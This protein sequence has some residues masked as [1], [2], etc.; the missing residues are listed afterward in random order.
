VGDATLA[1]DA[2]DTAAAP[3]F[4]I[5]IPQYN[6]TDFLLEAIRS[7]A[8]QDF[9]DFEVCIS[10]G[11]STD[12]GT[13]RIEAA[14]KTHGL[15]YVLSRSDRNL[16]YD[17]N[18]RTSIAS[19]KGR[20]LLLMGNDDALADECTLSQIR[21]V[22]DAN[23][24][25]AVAITNYLELSTSTH[26]RRMRS[27]EVLGSGPAVAASTYRH[28]S[29]VSGV[30]L[31]GKG[32]REAPTDACDGG[33]MYQMY[34]GSRLIA[35]GGRFLSIDSTCVH[36]DIQISGRAVDSY[37][38]RP[39]LHPCPL[40]ER[41]LPMGRILQTVEFGM[42]S[43]ASESAT[44]EAA[45]TIARQL[46]MF[47]YPYWVF[48]YRRVQSFKYALGVYM[49]L[50]PSVTTRTS[51]ITWSAK[52]VCWLAYLGFGAAAFATPIA[53]FDRARPLLYAIAK[54]GRRSGGQQVTSVPSHAEAP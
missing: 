30:I 32:S 46:Y 38:S 10:D 26:Y 4:S 44:R 6:R 23:A 53:V 18:L 1:A 28:Y 35:G 42:V 52:T 14:L 43:A 36:K 12:A 50:R 31:D 8:V 19:S 45:G 2:S 20:Y 54:A 29:F 17:E 16:Q 51:R 39:R 13:D 15:R 9:Q 25:V 11:G 33:E 34:L 49:A 5:C 7:F 47:T 3:Y 37:R 41:P 27:T 40:V 24:P 48:E 22:L 21:R